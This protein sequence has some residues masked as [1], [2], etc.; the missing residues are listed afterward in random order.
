MA[1]RLLQAGDSTS[2]AKME[3]LCQSTLGSRKENKEIV[4]RDKIRLLLT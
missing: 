3:Q 4:C 2:E 1:T